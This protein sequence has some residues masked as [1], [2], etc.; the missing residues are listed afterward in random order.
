MAKIIL[1]TQHISHVVVYVNLREGP[2]EVSSE[3]K[4]HDVNDPRGLSCCIVSGGLP[5]IADLST[6]REFSDGSDVWIV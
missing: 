3:V 2:K 1:R 6:F 4:A 5:E